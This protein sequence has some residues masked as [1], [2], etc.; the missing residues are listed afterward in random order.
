MQFLKLTDTLSLNFQNK[1]CDSTEKSV[2]VLSSLIF[3]GFLIPISS[4]TIGLG[5]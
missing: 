5:A 3:V 2:L 4:E 1:Y